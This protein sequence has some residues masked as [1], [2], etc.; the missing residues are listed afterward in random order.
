MNLKERRKFPRF[1]TDNLHLNITLKGGGSQSALKIKGRIVDV[2]LPGLQM[3]TQYPVASK[4]VY[5][6]VTDPENNPNEIR[7][8]V[9]Y[10]EKFSPK[11]FHV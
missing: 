9:V 8:R 2:S 5:L 11:K 6:K 4:D 10:C 1:A 7:G 3:E